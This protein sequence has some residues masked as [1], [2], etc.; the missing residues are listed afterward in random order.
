MVKI[1]LGYLSDGN[2]WRG[3]VYE[4]SITNEQGALEYRNPDKLSD[5]LEVKCGGV[6]GN[7]YNPDIPN[8]YDVGRLEIIKTTLE[9]RLGCIVE[10]NMTASTSDYWGANSEEDRKKS[11]TIPY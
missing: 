6:K 11:G 7:T 3:R 4:S 1:V 2:F 8:N 5:Y 10:Y 9:E